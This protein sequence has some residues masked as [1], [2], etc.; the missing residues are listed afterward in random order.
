[1]TDRPSRDLPQ[2]LADTL[3]ERFTELGNP[4]SRM[5][6]NFQGPDGWP[7]SRSVSPKDV[8]DVLRELL[9]PA[10]EQPARR[11]LTELEHT[12]AWHAIEGLDWAAGPDP[13]TVLNAV[14][15]ALRIDP[16]GAQADPCS[17]CRYAP[18]GTCTPAPRD[19]PS[20]EV[21]I[22][23]TEHCPTPETHNWGC[24]CPAGKRPDEGLLPG[25]PLTDEVRARAAAVLPPGARITAQALRAAEGAGA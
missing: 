6:I 23:H 15:A 12:A 14:L 19:C 3:T 8:A 18:C 13:D 25:A 7:A 17:G 1:M 9:G 22:E 21:G 24:G 2:V 5:S 10:S 20:C 11:R 16:P 4:F